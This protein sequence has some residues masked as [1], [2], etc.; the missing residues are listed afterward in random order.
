MSRSY[1]QE[2]ELVQAEYEAARL[3]LSHIAR[4]WN[5][6]TVISEMDG[7]RLEDFRR[8]DNHLE[9]TYIIRLFATFEGLLKEYL[10]THHTEITLPHQPSKMQVGWFVNRVA[11]LQS[12]PISANLIRSVEAVRNCRNDLM[13]T[14]RA[15]SP[16][17]SIE[18]ALLALGKYLDKLPRPR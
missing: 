2:L 16:I 11:Q 5:T 9:V 6:K 4:F 10:T 17:V 7:R 13:H 15:T 14:G 12:P 18:D 1:K 3:A 8:A